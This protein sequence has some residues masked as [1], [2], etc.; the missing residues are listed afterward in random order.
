MIYIF[1]GNDIEKKNLYLKKLF[2]NSQ[3][4]LVPNRDV[5]REMLLSQIGSVSLFGEQSIFVFENFIGDKIIDLKDEEISLLKESLNIF[6][7]KE[8]KLLAPDLKKFKKHAQIEEVSF[9]ALK[10]K[11]KINIFN[12]ADA[13]AKKDKIQ[14]WTLYI[15]A[16][17][18]GIVPEEISG[19]LFWKIKTM[20]L[21]GTKV[22][23]E[24]ELKLRSSEL[25]SL[26]HMAHR[27][28][29]DFT[30]GLEQFI[31]KSLNK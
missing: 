11:P 12:I 6:I 16:I 3:P 23:K 26:Y 8:D 15:E 22:F 19:I 1:F 20:I 21:N 4:I 27:G 7:F 24:D 29:V 14:T 31:L 13:F 17:S 10:Q 5:S 2:K 30:I 28:E 9:I 25:V 18:V